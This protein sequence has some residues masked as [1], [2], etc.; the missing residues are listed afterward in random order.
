MG[1]EGRTGNLSGVDAR[2]KFISKEQDAETGFYFFGPRPYNSLIGRFYT[3]D[4]LHYTPELA[5][6]SP[7]HYSFDNP[8]KFRDETGKFPWI[9]IALGY[10]AT[11]FS[12]DQPGGSPSMAG[13]LAFST[14]FGAAMGTPSAI[15]W[16][17]RNPVTATAVTTGVAES[18][19]PGAETLSPPSMAAKGVTEVGERL[20]KGRC[21]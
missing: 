19:L 9:V 14:G 2:Y 7:Y 1:L 13:H 16:A 4:P 10:L 3:V 5:G 15:M 21:K 11:Q 12:G 18:M 17:L 8:L 6:W 20:A